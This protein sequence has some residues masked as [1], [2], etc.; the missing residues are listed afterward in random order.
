MKLSAAIL[1]L[2]L[3]PKLLSA[4]EGQ[5]RRSPNAVKGEYIVVL[6]DDTPK[7]N[8][9][10]VA[11]QLA[12][13]HGGS[14]KR[15]WQDALKGYFAYMT[16]GQAQGL[17][18]DPKVKYIEENSAMF[19]SGTTPTRINPST[20]PPTPTTDNRLWYLDR[21]DQ[22]KAAPSYEYDYCNDG[23]GVYVY[24]IDTGVMAAHQEFE[25]WTV[26]SGYNASDDGAYYPANNPCHGSPATITPETVGAGH[27][28]G[29]AS[30]VAGRTV[31]V[32][33]GATIVPVKV[34]NCADLVRRS[35]DLG[36]GQHFDAGEIVAFN[37]TDY[38]CSTAGTTATTLPT[39]PRPWVG[40]PVC[41]IGGG[42]HDGTACFDYFGTHLAQTVAMVID[43]VDW[44]LRDANPWPKAHQ[45]ATF[46]T[47]RMATGPN[48]DATTQKNIGT[49]P[50]LISFEEAVL[51]LINAG[52]T[53]VA[54][55]NNQNANACDTSPA[56]LSRTSPNAYLNPSAYKVITVGGTMLVNNPDGPVPQGDQP[57]QELHPADGGSIVHTVEPDFDSTKPVQDA[58]WRCTKGDSDDCTGDV[59]ASPEATADPN[60]T[61][62]DYTKQTLGSNGGQCVTLFAPAKNIPVA[63]IIGTNVYRNSR[64]SGAGPS[65]ASA[66]A[67][68]TSWSAPIVA[69]VIARMMGANPNYSVD[70]V[71]NNLMFSYVS[72]DLV[73]TPA[74]PLNPPG[75]TGTP[76]KVLHIPDVN[77][78]QL[79]ATS[80]NPVTAF[81][82]GTGALSY[83]WY[84]VP[85]GFNVNAYSSGAIASSPVSGATSPVFSTIP[86][87]PTSYFV[88]VT[89]ICGSSDSN[90]TTIS[91][92]SAVINW[93]PVSSPT[94]VTLNGSATLSIGVTGSV[95]VIQWYTSN[96]V[97]VGSGA[98]IIVTPTATTIYHAMISNPCTSAFSSSPVTVTVV[99]PAP[100]AVNAYVSYHLNQ[101]YQITVTW[102]GSAGA[103]S[104]QRQRCSASGCTTVAAASGDIDTNVVADTTYVYTVRAVDA[105]SNVSAFSSADLATTITFTSL[106]S[107]V[108]SISLSHLTELLNGVNAVR[109][110]S[111]VGNTTALTWQGVHDN[112]LA[113][114]PGEP[115]PLPTSNGL[116]YAVHIKSLREEMDAARG[117]VGVPTPPYTDALTPLSTL[118]KAVHFSELQDRT[119]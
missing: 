45:V 3:I 99:P 109:A 36:R 75:V 1:A 25:S 116:V 55:A 100:T 59:L 74:N 54:S 111:M 31:G 10:D 42:W 78:G 90:I 4:G 70:D 28:T 24:V 88:R 52:I 5:V 51:N 107:F 110:A 104:Y 22:T 119:Q 20:N 35:L 12:K 66:G 56:R 43:G 67:S 85:S 83:Q 98:S 71:Y 39:G 94:A 57:G 34:A 17:S 37:G 33:K 7:A 11:N 53:V 23:S 82:T 80:I 8:V 93:Q 69:G 65:G 46:S 86:M 68:G 48:A 102:Q 15:V 60:S 87:V 27:G 21:L 112:Y 84:Q 114:H 95:P 41:A 63:S 113:N 13:Q 44:I 9:P 91:C 30:L 108:T 40:D 97:F 50:R 19:L 58:R 47:Y 101:T 117:R 79:P 18:H 26:L 105:S 38:I 81:A 118:I 32:A 2:L 72:S 73:D 29:V 115:F 62:T 64:A 96:N 6:N 16:E 14:V 77:I 49:P 61:V 103:V 92:Q 106:Q 76:N 89:G